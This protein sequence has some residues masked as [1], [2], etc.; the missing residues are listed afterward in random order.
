MADIGPPSIKDVADFA[1]VIASHPTEAVVSL[2]LLT[3]VAFVIGYTSKLPTTIMS[4]VVFLVL[5]FLLFAGTF[6]VYRL[7]GSSSDDTAVV[8]G[9]KLPDGTIRVE[10]VALNT[11]VGGVDG[12]ALRHRVL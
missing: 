6:G 1:D 12:D 4:I 7:F 2:V 9:F 11:Y 8:F 5:G 10:S 3:A